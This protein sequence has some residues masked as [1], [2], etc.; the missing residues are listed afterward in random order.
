MPFYIVTMSY[1]MPSSLPFGGIRFLI[2]STRVGD[3]FSRAEI[4]DM[5]AYLWV[6]ENPSDTLRLK[7]I[8]N[9][10]AR[11]IGARS[12]EIAE[13]LAAENDITLYEVGMPCRCIY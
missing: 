2:G 4:R 9:V 8:I 10:P 12:I 11:K 6:I 5:F 13:Q 1:R 7:R 3:F